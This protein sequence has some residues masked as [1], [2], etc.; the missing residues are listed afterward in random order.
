MDQHAELIRLKQE[1]LYHKA[2]SAKYNKKI[3]DLERAAQKEIIRN[4]FLQEK[5]KEWQVEKIR[6]EEG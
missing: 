2:E 1:I 3:L 4:K 6:I 5:R